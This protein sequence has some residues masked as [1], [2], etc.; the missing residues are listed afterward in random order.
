MKPDGGKNELAK[1][2]ENDEKFERKKR[3][4]PRA[5][6]LEQ[7]LKKCESFAGI[8][9]DTDIKNIIIQE[10]P[11]SIIVLVNSHW[12]MIYISKRKLEIYASLGDIFSENYKNIQR[13]VSKNLSGKK[14]YILHQVQSDDSLYCSYFVL[15]FSALKS[16]GYSFLNILNEFSFNFE[17]NQST[18]FSFVDRFY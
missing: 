17:R 12:M 7:K 18:V 1:L 5:K 14:L 16:M 8:F 2:R 15:C 3:K 6:E 11:L 10:Y 4:V 9:K 13:F